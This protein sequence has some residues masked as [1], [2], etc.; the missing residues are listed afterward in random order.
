MA[1][2]ARVTGRGCPL[3]WPLSQRLYGVDLFTTGST[4]ERLLIAPALTAALLLLAGQR[5]GIWPHATSWLT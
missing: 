4:V 2:T 1:A 5:A 3:A